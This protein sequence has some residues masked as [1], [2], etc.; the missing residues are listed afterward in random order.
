MNTPLLFFIDWNTFLIICSVGTLDTY[1]TLLYLQFWHS[2]DQ[3]LRRRSDLKMMNSKSSKIFIIDYYHQYWSSNHEK[4][5]FQWYKCQIIKILY[6]HIFII[7]YQFIENSGKFWSYL[8]NISSGLWDIQKW[9]SDS[10]SATQNW[11]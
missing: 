11:L 3:Y 7:N 9:I 1:V 6:F 4:I 8:S 5:F 10:E 2:Y